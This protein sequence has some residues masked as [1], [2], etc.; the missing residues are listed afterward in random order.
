MA[1]QSE[2]INEL[3]KALVEVQRN[4]APVIKGKSN[5]FFKSKYADLTSIWDAL[6]ESLADNGLAVLQTN[7][8]EAENAVTIVTTLAHTS[9]QWIRG[10]LHM[11]LAKNDP[12]GVGSAITYGRRYTLAAMLGVA[13]E[14][15]DGEGAM[16]R[17]KA[18]KHETPPPAPPPPEPPKQVAKATKAPKKDFDPV[19]PASEKQIEWVAKAWADA[20]GYGVAELVGYLT[21]N[22][23]AGDA[24][25]LYEMAHTGTLDV[26]EFERIAKV[27]PQTKPDELPDWMKPGGESH[28]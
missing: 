18:A 23:L 1:E 22:L 13:P 8:G 4:M 28:A 3:V 9:G 24:K 7:D 21:D 2:Q 17:G 27:P 15:D 10:R 14:D 5:P 6:R 11:P 25:T 12:Q 20:T 26:K 19:A 16:G